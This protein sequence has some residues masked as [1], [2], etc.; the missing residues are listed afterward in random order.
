MDNRD[1]NKVWKVVAVLIAFWAIVGILTSCK[2]TEYV[3]VTQNETKIE[4]RDRIVRDTIS[5]RDS[6]VIFAKS[7]TIY[8]IKY[9][10]IYREKIRTDT[11]YVSQVD[12]LILTKEIE[13]KLSRWQQTKME[14]GGYAITMLI[15]AIIALIVYVSLKL[16]KR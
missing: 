1:E 3:P 13:K 10:E 16:Y 9:H 12:T 15:L 8:Q 11:T 5:V 7:D 6:V 14:A 2:T 4:Y